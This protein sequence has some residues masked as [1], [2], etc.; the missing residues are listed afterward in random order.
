[1]IIEVELLDK[2]SVKVRI[3]LD[4]GCLVAEVLTPRY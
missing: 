1:M 4:L 3:M 2:D